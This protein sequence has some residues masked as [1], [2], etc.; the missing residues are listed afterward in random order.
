MA[1]LQGAAGAIF[2]KD[3]GKNRLGGISTDLF[4]KGFPGYDNGK[5]VGFGLAIT[6]VHIEQKQV[7]R[8]VR[9]LDHLKNI[10]RPERSVLSKEP[11]SGAKE[12]WQ[13]PCKSKTSR[14]GEYGFP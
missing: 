3:V 12:C 7:S 4:G 8:V 13:Y 2:R 5:K 6:V 10:D 9:N 1:A 11:A 14:I